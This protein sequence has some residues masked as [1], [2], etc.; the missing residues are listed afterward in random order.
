MHR[1]FFLGANS[2]V[3]FRSFYDEF[4]CGDGDFLY[5]IKA[6]PGG[7]KSGFMRKIGEK[8]EECGFDVEYILCSGDPDSLDGVY[9]PK[10]GLG[11]SDATAPHAAEPPCFGY[12]SSYVNL[13]R[14]CGKVCD[15]E[16]KTHQAVYRAYYARAYSL[17]S[18]AAELKKARF[19]Q[20][21]SEKELQKC[22]D[23]AKSAVNKELGNKRKGRAGT[24]KHRFISAISC[25]GEIVLTGSLLELCKHIYLLDDRFGLAS[26][27]LETIIAEAK[28]RGADMIVCPSPLL[29]D[30]PEAVIFPESSLGFVSASLMPDEKP[31]RHVRLDA[32][33]PDNRVRSVRPELRRAEKIYRALMDDAVLNLAHAK[34]H[35]DR[36]EAVYKPCVDFAAL[37]QYTDEVIKTVF[38]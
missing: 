36:L 2:G 26:Y 3:G 14:F 23:R 24:V 27:Y 7:G 8:A 19:P 29:P 15:N 9:I 31:Y 11:F 20:L 5:L 21:I 33:I 13:G 1:D 16:I 37:T 32:L 17:L 28:T 10:L 35:H 18:A 38:G 30:T 4:C 34:E 6:G 22:T 25:K 12:D